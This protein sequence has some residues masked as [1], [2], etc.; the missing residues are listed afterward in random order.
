MPLTRDWCGIVTTTSVTGRV[1]MKRKLFGLMT[2]P[3][4]D[5]ELERGDWARD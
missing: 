4:H 5:E 3:A 1:K 2:C